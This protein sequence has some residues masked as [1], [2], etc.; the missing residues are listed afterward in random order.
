MANKDV[1]FIV[2][3]SGVKRFFVFLVVLVLAGA[4]GY[5][6]WQYKKASDETERAKQDVQR[7][8]DPTAAA[9]DAEDQIIVSVKKIAL[10]PDERPTISPAITDAT[11]LKKQPLYSLVENGDRVLLYPSARRQIVYRPSTNQI[12][13]AITLPETDTTQP[14][15]DTD[16]TEPAQQ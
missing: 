7:L 8:S 14:V 9:K 10:V 4:A 13:L 5:A 12:I 15:E 3:R 16:Q 2:T 11:E 6:S 1:A